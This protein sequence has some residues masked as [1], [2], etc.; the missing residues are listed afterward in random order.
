MNKKLLVILVILVFMLT[1][2]I[3]KQDNAFKDLDIK[4]SGEDVKGKISEKLDE[5]E[6]LEILKDYY[7]SIERNISED[8]IINNIKENI[9]KLDENKADE[10]LVQL[11]NYLY[12]KAYDAK[13]VTEKLAP[14]VENASDEF[15]SYFKIWKTETE[16]ETTDGEGLKI[17]AEEI[18][19]R[20]LEIERHNKR[21]P[22]DKLKQRLDD[23]YRAYISLSLKGLGNP[24]IFAK[25]GESTLDPDILEMYKQKID[26]NPDSRTAKKIGRASCRERV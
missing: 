8:Q 13:K 22:T 4:E 1:G 26:E 25:E 21:F 5:E 19:D 7:E 23:L 6:Q 12:S 20:A 10:M 24:Y 9:A 18:I 16:N 2:C 3:P 15:R 17:S 11:E 14:F